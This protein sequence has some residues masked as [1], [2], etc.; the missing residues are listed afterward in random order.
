MCAYAR[1]RQLV[2][3]KWWSREERCWKF[4][5]FVDTSVHLFWW[6][7]GM[8]NQ[9]FC[10]LLSDN[11]ASIGR[12][13][14]PLYTRMWKD[15]NKCICMWWIEEKNISRFKISNI[16][17]EYRP[18]VHNRSKTYW[19]EYQ[20]ITCSFIFFSPQKKLS[21]DSVLF[22]FQITFLFWLSD[23]RSLHLL[24]TPH[25]YIHI[26]INIFIHINI[27][28]RIF[29]CIEWIHKVFHQLLLVRLSIYNDFRVFLHSVQ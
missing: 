6:L 9:H 4:E 7:F 26:Y 20:F 14:P 15:I 17:I 21:Y 12:Q 25:I 1:R 22:T 16:S 2:Q 13:V 23:I 18:R 28:F 27:S 5:L 19:T 3:N 8:K 10:I 29:A 24:L 11:A